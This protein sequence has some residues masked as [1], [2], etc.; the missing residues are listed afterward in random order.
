MSKYKTV[1]VKHGYSGWGGPIEITPTDE[2]KYIVSMTGYAIH[3]VARQL[4]D[5][6]GGELVNAFKK[7]VP[8]KEMAA[9]VI[10]CGGVARCWEF[11]KKRVQTIQT[12]PL[13]PSGSHAEE[14]S[15]LFLVT[16]VRI[17]CLSLKE[18]ALEE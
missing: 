14:I 5:L 13:V 6:T 1:I 18:T 4:A 15:P 8:V 9:L 12:L 3:E 2:K 11:P 10:N 17:N 16:D 7:N